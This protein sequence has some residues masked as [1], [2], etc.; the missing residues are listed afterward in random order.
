M[1]ITLLISIVL[2][3]LVV[4]AFLRNVWA[5]VIPSIAVPLSL[6]GTFG[7][8]YLPDTRSTIFR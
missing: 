7:V 1:E 8:M 5:T 2:V 6:V 3:V 4:F